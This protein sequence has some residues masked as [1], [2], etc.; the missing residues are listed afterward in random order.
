M[1]F[2]PGS[3]E[4]TT[5]KLSTDSFGWKPTSSAQQHKLS[6]S[7]AGRDAPRNSHYTVRSGAGAGLHSG[8]RMHALLPARRL[9]VPLGALA[10]PAACLLKSLLSPVRRLKPSSSSSTPPNPPSSLHAGRQPLRPRWEP[11][12]DHDRAH[13]L[14]PS[15][16][17]TAQDEP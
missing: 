12:P 3:R 10:T 9:P 4:A 8:A 7:P 14:T 2:F 11:R 16:P 17:C 13:N 1:S 6:E 5:F 15:D